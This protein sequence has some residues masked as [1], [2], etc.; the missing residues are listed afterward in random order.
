MLKVKYFTFNP[1][2]ENTY[3]VFDEATSDAAIIDPGCHTK[4]EQEQ[5]E[6][7][8]EEHELVPNFVLNTHCHIDHV[9]GNAYAK[10]KWDIPLLIHEKDKPTLDAIPAYAANYGFHNYEPS[11][12]DDFLVEGKPLRIGSHQVNIL[13]VPGHAPGHVVFY[14]LDEKFCINGDCLFAGSIGRTDLPGGDYDT[15]ITNIR[16]KLFTLP[17]ETV[18]YCGHGPA[19]TIGKEKKTNPFFKAS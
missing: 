5:L 15:L 3:I 12:P 16:E 17:D 11:T 6:A 8:I 18:V 19:T 7:Y 2:A 10:K 1:F 14:A 4:Q 13:F 9:L